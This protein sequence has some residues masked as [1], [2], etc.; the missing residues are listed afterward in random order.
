ME[1][2]VRS[3]RG[4][5]LSDISNSIVQL[6]KEYYGK[7]PERVRTT[8]DGDLVVVLMHGGFTRVEQSLLDGGHGDAVI[9]QRMAFQD[10]MRP[11]FSEAI[12]RHTGRKVIGFMSGSHQDPDLLA[13]IFI[14]QPEKDKLF[15]DAQ[16]GDGVVA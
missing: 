8:Y 11:Q 1:G 3:D 9:A 15:V 16:A 5:M 2:R 4:E 12:E 10:L 7:G 14:L 13:E 6:T